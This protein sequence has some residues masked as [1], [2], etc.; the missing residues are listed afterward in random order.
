MKM[1]DE[2]Q[3][4]KIVPYVI[5]SEIAGKSKYWQVAI[6]GLREQGAISTIQAAN[7]PTTPQDQEIRE[8]DFCFDYW[9]KGKSFSP[10]VAA[11]VIKKASGGCA[12]EYTDG[13]GKKL[14]DGVKDRLLSRVPEDQFVKLTE[15]LLVDVGIRDIVSDIQKAKETLGE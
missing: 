5:T 3:E 15:Q 8:I 1:S 13:Y 9:D 11:H 4:P 2:K 14:E 12:I 6:G 10:I 7:Q